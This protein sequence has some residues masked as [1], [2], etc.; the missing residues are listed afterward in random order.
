MLLRKKIKAIK[1]TF[2]IIS[3]LF[4]LSGRCISSQLTEKL[5]EAGLDF[6][7]NPGDFIF[8]LH[9]DTM[10]YTPLPKNKFLGIH[11]NIL[12]LANP[13]LMNSVT[14]KVAVGGEKMLPQVGAF[15]GAWKTLALDMFSG[16]LGMSTADLSGWSAGFFVA[17]NV[18]EDTRLFTNVNYSKFNL[19]IELEEP[20]II[21]EDVLEFPG[22][23]GDAYDT[24]IFTGIECT[25]GEYRDKIVIAQTGYG[26]RTNKIVAKILIHKGTMEFGLTIYPE[27]LLVIH[28][29]LNMQ[30]RF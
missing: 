20:L 3:C 1:I 2:I 25:V 12:L 4:F 23:S 10:D 6:I 13:A 30:F 18:D 11:T 5:I 26:I 19:N 29:V 15:Y 7:S 14:V 16:S 28:P 9:H 27:G 21:I 22:L 17:I 8:D 24:F